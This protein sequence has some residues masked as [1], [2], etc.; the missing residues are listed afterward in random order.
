MKGLNPQ[1]A[2]FLT[3]VLVNEL[4]TISLLQLGETLGH[5]GNRS[6]LF[7]MKRL[8]VAVRHL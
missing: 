7:C 6:I 4:L 8:A 2:D 1:I 5:V 3:S